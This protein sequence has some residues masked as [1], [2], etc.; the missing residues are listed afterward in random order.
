MQ[1]FFRAHLETS[2]GNKTLGALDES[3]CGGVQ[4]TQFSLLLEIGHKHNDK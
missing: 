1:R 3:A 4:K 2:E